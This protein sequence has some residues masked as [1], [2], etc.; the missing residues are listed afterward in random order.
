MKAKEILRSLDADVTSLPSDRF[1]CPRAEKNWAK[2]FVYSN[3]YHETP[4]M[5]RAIMY[6]GDKQIETTYIDKAPVGV[7]QCGVSSSLSVDPI[8]G[9][10]IHNGR[11]VRPLR[12]NPED[13]YTADIRALFDEHQ[14]QVA[15][16]RWYAEAIADLL[17]QLGV[18]INRSLFL[19]LSRRFD[20]ALRHRTSAVNLEQSPFVVGAMLH[21]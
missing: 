10:I 4:R 16:N 21:G 7:I 12:M 18:T 20:A 8:P 13:E 15:G 3:R 5:K 2:Y 19:S 11:M 9:M 17:P 1:A 6:L 14:M